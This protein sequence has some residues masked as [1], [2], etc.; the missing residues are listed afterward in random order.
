MRWV[1]DRN[2]LESDRV[3]GAFFSAGAGLV[4]SAD[5]RI[6]DVAGEVVAD[7]EGWT[8][9]LASLKN[10]CGGAAV[11]VVAGNRSV[12]AFDAGAGPA[13]E[14]LSLGGQVS[15][16]WPAETPGQ[17]TLVVRNPA[18]GNYEASRLGA[19]CAE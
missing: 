15:A 1:S 11:V 3:R 12:Q 7:T 18:T 8:G 16:L 6:R 9:D 5:G 17:A 13:S 14:P 2:A 19:S 10:P 4:A